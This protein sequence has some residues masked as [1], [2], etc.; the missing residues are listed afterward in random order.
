[1]VPQV[2]PHDPQL[3][4][5][6]PVSTHA[7]PQRVKPALQLNPHVVPSHVA[8]A[9]AGGAHALH[10]A[11]HV[12][13]LVLLAHAAPHTTPVRRVDEGRAARHL[14]ATEDDRASQSAEA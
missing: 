3:L 11:P 5:S 6:F 1:M 12:A 7:P 9:L 10:E 14:I 2:C 4:A 13:T 8:A